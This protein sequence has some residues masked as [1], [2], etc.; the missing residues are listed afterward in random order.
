MVKNP[1]ADAGDTRDSGLVLGVEGSSGTGLATLSS[2][3]AH[4]LPWTEEPGRLQSIASH[5][6]RHN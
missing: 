6:V 1:S 3:L 4:R 2:I 5:R